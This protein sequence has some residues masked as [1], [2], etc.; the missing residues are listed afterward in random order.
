[1]NGR[2]LWTRYYVGTAV[3]TAPT[4]L[5]IWDGGGS[6][7]QSGPTVSVLGTTATSG[8]W[9]A[10][11]TANIPSLPVMWH[12]RE[13]DARTHVAMLIPVGWYSD[14]SSDREDR[15]T[16]A[17]RGAEPSDPPLVGADRKSRTAALMAVWLTSVWQVEASFTYFQPDLVSNKPILYFEVAE[18][19]F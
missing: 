9:G 2:H 19:H 3:S 16:L 17:L 8:L 15:T 7:D 12:I 1:M 5:H 6:A 11:L 4:Q 13:Q 14:T 18:P 10:E